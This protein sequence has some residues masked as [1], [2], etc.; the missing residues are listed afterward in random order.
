MQ[1]IVF[2]VHDM[3]FSRLHE[4]QVNFLNALTLN[5]IYPSYKANTI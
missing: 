5:L 3:A 4:K 1:K 2:G